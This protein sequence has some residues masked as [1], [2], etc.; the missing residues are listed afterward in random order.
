[1][2]A[3][4]RRP[5]RPSRPSSCHKDD[6]DEVRLSAATIDGTASTSSSDIKNY[7]HMSSECVSTESC[8]AV[9][10]GASDIETRATVGEHAVPS[11]HMNTDVSPVIVQSDKSDQSAEVQQSDKTDAGLSSSAKSVTPVKHAVSS[12]VKCRCSSKSR[13][14]PPVPPPPT[15]VSKETTPFS[16]DDDDNTAEMLPVKDDDDGE[17]GNKAC[18]NVLRDLL[19]CNKYTSAPSSTS[20][21]SLDSKPSSSSNSAGSTDSK[22]AL[23]PKPVTAVARESAGSEDISCSSHSAKMAGLPSSD[24]S[25]SPEPTSTSSASTIDVPPVYAVVNKSRTLRSTSNIH[26]DVGNVGKPGTNVTVAR[27]KSTVVAGTVPPKKPPRTFAHSEYMQLKSLSLP[28]S[29]EP[30]RSSEYEEVGSSTKTVPASTD[31]DTDSTAKASEDNV[32]GECKVGRRVHESTQLLTDTKECSLD[33]SG[34]VKRQ[35]SDKLPA[36]P[37]PPPPSFTDNRSSTLST[38]LSVADTDTSAA[39]LSKK[40]SSKDSRSDRA[41]H[42]SLSVEEEQK[43]GTRPA[44]GSDVIDDD[45]DI[46]AVPADINSQR[47]SDVTHNAATQQSCLTCTASATSEMTRLTLHPVGDHFVVL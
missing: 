27:S 32:D 12:K 47:A 1:M 7:R 22:P 4:P 21:N 6:K 16:A 19:P 17:N 42:S 45:D 38:R 24:A 43:P 18:G 15:S 39:C 35:Q 2:S 44:S 8:V 46:Y 29:S 26:G 23:K 37:R 10:C 36:P 11:E 41:E 5:P 33:G 40:Y 31:G 20:T 28:R 30:S 14:A 34:K 9:N 3:V 13:K 25:S